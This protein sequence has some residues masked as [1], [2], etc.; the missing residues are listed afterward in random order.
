MSK[1]GL[2]GG[3]KHLLGKIGNVRYYRCRACGMI[4]ISKP[5]PLPS[6]WNV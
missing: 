4:F 2:C 6:M 1:C 5:R 3:D